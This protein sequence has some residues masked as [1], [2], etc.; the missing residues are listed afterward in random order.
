FRLVGSGAA[1]RLWNS[2]GAAV[3]KATPAAV[4]ALAL[5]VGLLCVGCRPKDPPT[6]VKPPEP[7]VDEKKPPSPAVAAFGLEVAAAFEKLESWYGVFG[8]NRFGVV[9]FTRRFGAGPGV[10]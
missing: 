1:S 5:S 8:T 10:P 9:V 4:A 3:P 7:A 6:E 2:K